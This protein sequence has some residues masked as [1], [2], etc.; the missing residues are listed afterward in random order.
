MPPPRILMCPPDYY[1]IEYEINPWMSRSRG[2]DHDLAARQWGGLVAILRDLGVQIDL[3]TP[4]PGL[5]DLVFTANAGLIFQGT[6]YSARFRHSE[7]A[8]ESPVF[9]A[10]FAAHGFAVR[11][12]PEGMYHEGAGDAL[13]CGDPL[14]AGYR[15][16]SDVFG[17]QWLGETLGV[18]VLPLE[19]VNGHFYHVDTCFCPLAPGEALWY[20]GAFDDYARKVLKT[21]IKTLIEVDEAEANRFGCNAVVVGKTVVTNT[22][23]PKMAAALKAR[24]YQPV[25]TP[26]DEFLKAGGS[27]KCLTLRLDGEEAAAWKYK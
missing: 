27:A 16:R 26:L 2:S 20:P 21:H 6:F 1:G 15:I 4:Q 10:W 3:M 7:R 11:H 14:F 22:G 13:F 24:G 12:L 23:C 19:L 9:D 5:P 25:E 8:R 18:Q 17:H